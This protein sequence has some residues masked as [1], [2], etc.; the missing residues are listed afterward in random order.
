MTSVYREIDL[1]LAPVLAQME[2]TGIRVDTGVLAELSTRL[3]LRIEEFAQQ[4]YQ[5]AGHP[6]NINSP[7]QLGKVLFEEIEAAR[8]GEVRKGKD[9]LDG[10]RCAGGTRAEVSGGAMVLEY[11]QLTK[12]KGTYVD[13]L[14]ALI[15]PRDGPRCTRRSI[16]RARR[17]GGCLR[18]IPTCRTSRSA[19]KKAGRFAPRSCRSR[20]GS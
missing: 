2:E 4:I 20:V 14:P 7:Q 18:R 12:L 6:F 5:H 16:R 8:A 11:R 19:P 1:P 3:A 10:G 13:A 17:R 9:H 15:R